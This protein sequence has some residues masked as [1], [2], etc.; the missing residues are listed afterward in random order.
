MLKLGVQTRTPSNRAMLLE[1]RR[2]KPS[3]ESY[4]STTKKKKTLLASA[5]TILRARV[6]FG[7]EFVREKRALILHNINHFLMPYTFCLESN[8]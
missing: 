6:H 8:K 2:G 4:I 5:A 7:L 3:S 1:R